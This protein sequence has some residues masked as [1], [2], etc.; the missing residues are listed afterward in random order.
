MRLLFMSDTSSPQQ[1]ARQRETSL[2]YDRSST[3]DVV[4]SDI[5]VNDPPA[6]GAPA[7]TTGM[8]L[9]GDAPRLASAPTIATPH[10]ER[11]EPMSPAAPTAPTL[12]AEAPTLPVVSPVLSSPATP[13]LP[14]PTTVAEHAG[15][16]GEVP[17]TADGE[18]EHPMAHLM[19]TR[20]MPT[21]ASR[22]AAEK[23]A[24]HK[25][26]GKKVKIGVISGM[27]IFTAV[28][29]PP[30]GKWLVDAV[31]EAGDTSTVEEPAE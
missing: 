23:R 11:I 8:F 1:S 30:L 19:P 26:K 31:N 7:E 28:V 6:G 9:D 24:A 18:P 20:T 14:S 29:G 25:A 10:S 5:V 4:M 27:L 2:K 17:T 3:D 16:P 12:L 13:L 15:T 22:R 21:E